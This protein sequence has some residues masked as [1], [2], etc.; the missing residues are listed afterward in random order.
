MSFSSL[1]ITLHILEVLFFYHF[2]VS[3]HIT[4]KL[5]NNIPTWNSLETMI[6]LYRLSAFVIK[7]FHQ[8]KKHIF[9][10]DKTLVRTIEWMLTKQKPDGSFPEPGRVIHKDMQVSRHYI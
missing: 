6:L 1:A 7:T 8:A 5:F 9:I 10:D 4:I 3:L 2:N